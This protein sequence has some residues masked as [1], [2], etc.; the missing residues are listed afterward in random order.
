VFA[1]QASPRRALRPVVGQSGAADVDGRRQDALARG[2]VK[3]TGTWNLGTRAGDFIFV[4]GIRGI[5]PKTNSLVQGE[6]ARVRQAFLNMKLIAESEGAT[7]R[8]GADPDKRW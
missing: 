5:D 3:P 8:D 7:L 6:E 4:A 2:A 1:Q